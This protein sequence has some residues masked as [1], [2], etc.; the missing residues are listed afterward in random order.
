MPAR[1]DLSKLKELLKKDSLPQAKEVWR[2]ADV[3][4][5]LTAPELSEP[6]FYPDPEFVVT[7][8]ALEVSWFFDQIRDAFYNDELIDY[9]N[10]YM[11]FG[12]MADAANRVIKA[13]VNPSAKLICA[14]V[15]KEAEIMLNELMAG[16]W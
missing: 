12:R 4:I 10:K 2:G 11:F 7:E 14:G 9:M 8:H 15:L 5:L 13:V 1:E 3:A 6:G 16:E